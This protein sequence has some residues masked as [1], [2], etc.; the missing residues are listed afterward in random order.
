MSAGASD[1][2][3]AHQTVHVQRQQNRLIG[4]LPFQ[5]GTELSGG[6]PDMSGD[7]PNRCR[8]MAW[9]MHLYLSHAQGY[10]YLS[11]VQLLIS[12]C[13]LVSNST[14]YICHSVEYV[15]L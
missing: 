15:L 5:V 7:P 13:G 8:V 4:C 11:Q 3:V 10:I 1:C 9:K 2:P 12:C 14:F 6:T